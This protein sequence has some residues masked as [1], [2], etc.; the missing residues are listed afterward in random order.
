MSAAWVNVVTAETLV[1]VSWLHVGVQLAKSPRAWY[2]ASTPTVALPAARD[3]RRKA[4]VGSA[5]IA[6]DGVTINPPVGEASWAVPRA[7]T[8]APSIVTTC[9]GTVGLP[10]PSAPALR[11]MDSVVVIVPG[12]T[13]QGDPNVPRIA[14]VVM[15]SS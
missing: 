5:A 2:S 10:A 15:P 11:A 4:F 8:A 9:H 6:G 3:I 12:A 13:P 7:S 14:R 1:N